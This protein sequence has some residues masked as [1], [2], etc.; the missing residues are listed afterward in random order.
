[1]K[2]LI[3]L[4]CFGIITLAA[5]SPPS[6][7]LIIESKPPVSP[8]KAL[9]GATAWVESSNDTTALN[10]EE[11]AFGVY[12]IRAIR[13]KDYN[14][15]TGKG[16]TLQDC[17]NKQISDEIYLYYASKFHP[18]N[19][20]GVAKSWNGSGEMTKKYWDKIKKQLIKK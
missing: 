17:Y 13:L 19:L 2:K 15:R 4:L 1:M 16:Y 7:T 12:Q 20:E 14:T 11:L 6:N 18:S 10:L 3:L 9:M 5:G 8:F